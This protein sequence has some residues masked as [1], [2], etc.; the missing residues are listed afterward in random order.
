M[1]AQVTYE[2][3]EL[4]E[5]IDARISAVQVD[6]AILMSERDQRIG[7]SRAR[8]AILKGAGALAA[9]LVAVP[10]AVFYSGRF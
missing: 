6:V 4:L 8:R 10:T 3:K 9:I 2:A 5:R 7:E 1:S